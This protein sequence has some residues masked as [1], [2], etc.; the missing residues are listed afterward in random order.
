MFSGSMEAPPY[1]KKPI[2]IGLVSPIKYISV[3]KNISIAIIYE[4]S[5]KYLAIDKQWAT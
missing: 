2:K 3:N 4:D 1:W 5:L